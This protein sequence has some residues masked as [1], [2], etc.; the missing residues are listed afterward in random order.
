MNTFSALP[1]PGKV[2][3]YLSMARNQARF[4]SSFVSDYAN[5]NGVNNGAVTAGTPLA[6]VPQNLA[7]AGATWKHDGWR[8][9]AEGRFIG[10][11]YLDQINS[12]TPTAAVI[13]GHLVVNLGLSRVFGLGAGNSHETL[14][15]GLNVDNVFDRKYLN[16]G[17][18][19]MD[20]AGNNFIRGIYAAPRAV[21]GSVVYG[22]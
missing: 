2:D 15:I 22:F 4:T 5:A 20:A 7:S 10:R 11:Q 17:Y 6:D 12:G 18:T 16:S 13:G 9:N 14:R 21:T 8:A 19:D 1:V 3:A